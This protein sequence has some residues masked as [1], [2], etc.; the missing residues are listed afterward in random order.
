MRSVGIYSILIILM[1]LDVS[2][3]ADQTSTVTGRLGIYQ[4][5]YFQQGTT[6]RAYVVTETGTG[7]LFRLQNIDD[8]SA[9][10]LKSGDQ[11]VV[12][13][14]DLRTGL[15]PTD[16]TLQ[17]TNIRLTHSASYAQYSEIHKVLTLIVDLRDRPVLCSNENIEQTM[18]SGNLSVARLYEEISQQ[19][20]LFPSD[21]DNDG[22]SD[23]FRVTIDASATDTCDPWLWAPM[24][25]QVATSMGVNLS[26]YQHFMYVLPTNTTC[27][28]AGLGEIGC[29]EVCS[30]WVL[31]CQYPDIYAHELGHNLGFAHASADL[32]ND[33]VIDENCE[34]CDFSDIMGYS[35]VGW[36]GLNAPHEF[37]THWFHGGWTQEIAPWGSE[38][39]VIAP[40]QLGR[41]SSQ[42][43]Q[44][45][46]VPK[47]SDG[48]SY[49][50][51]YRQ[52]SG[53]DTSL[54]SL[55]A[56][57]VNIHTYNAILYGSA[58]HKTLLVGSYGDGEEF[59]DVSNH[60]AVTVL[61]HDEFSATVQVT[62]WFDLDPP[63]PIT[64]LRVKIWKN[65]QLLLSWGPSHDAKSGVAGYR[66]YR[67]DILLGTTTIPMF[68]DTTAEF[69]KR[70]AYRVTAFDRNGNEGY[71]RPVYITIRGNDRCRNGQNSTLCNTKITSEPR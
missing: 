5:D 49:Y 8:A 16:N 71:G 52:N 27:H 70:Y 57:R 35:G 17:V 2:R 7:K 39:Y 10:T 40:L 4:E 50:I 67:D 58:Y 62:A 46:K 28:W 19:D 63:D 21:V 26:L 11:V 1:F 55:F 45:L 34:Y 33:G 42:Y 29:P 65:H 9:S 25:K 18:F 64:D 66:V 48:N 61:D 30:T 15:A 12:Q 14:R 23:V 3:A 41:F 22:E 36:R 43:P 44:A 53:Y 31:A 37:Q 51:S 24:A 54:N 6:Q 38:T 32:N 60:I 69:K 13:G 47:S 68:H 59:A 56:G 20:I